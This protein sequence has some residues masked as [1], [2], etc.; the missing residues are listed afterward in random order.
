MELWNASLNVPF[1]ATVS[2]AVFHCTRNDP[3]PLS[4]DSV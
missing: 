1:P 3:V 4:N 2:F